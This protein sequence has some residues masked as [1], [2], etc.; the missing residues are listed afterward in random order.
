MNLSLTGK[1]A[2]ICGA[3]QGLG[4][5]SAKELALLGASCILLA[6]NEQSLSAAVAS[7]DTTQGQRH[8]YFV[9][10]FNKPENVKATIQAITDGQIVHILVNNTGGPSGGPILAAEGGA[11]IKA[12]EMHVVC[13]QILAQAVEPGMKASG[14]GRIIQVIS[15]SVKTP[16]K[17]LGVS[18]TIRAAVASWAKT[19]ATELAPFGIT[20]NNVLPGSMTTD[21]LRSIFKTNAEMRGVPVESVA[22]EWRLEIPMQRFGDPAEFGAA[23]AFLASP[24]AS[25]ITGINL[26]VDGGKTPSL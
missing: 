12:F 17:N 2:V 5:A 6:R 9:T 23:V 18:N 1:T 13:N 26:P 25:Y 7:L 14:Y 20:V 16:L 11:F 24:A 8:N 22:E 15:T 19:L 21:R 4:L 10:D 3:S